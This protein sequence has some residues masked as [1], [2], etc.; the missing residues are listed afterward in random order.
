MWRC[1]NCGN[2]LDA[3][4]MRNRV[5]QSAETILREASRKQPE[6]ESLHGV[7]PYSSRA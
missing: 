2:R 7:V 5:V 1:V 3:K 6:G 4:V